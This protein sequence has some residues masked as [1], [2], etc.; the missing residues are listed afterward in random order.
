MNREQLEHAL[1]AAS[2]IT[3]ER[4]MF[5]IGSQSI[6]GSFS[7]HM[8]PARAVQSEEV[9]V[10]FFDDPDG[11]KA[12]LVEGA[13]GEY[14]TFYDMFKFYVDGV[15]LT[16]AIL[17]EGWVDRLVD[18]TSART[19]GAVGRCLEPHDCVV[20]KMAAGREKDWEFVD[21]LLGAGLV[22]SDVL[23]ER[24]D[25]TEMHPLARQRATDWLVRFYPPSWLR[26]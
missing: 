18:V 6:L 17:P 9:D 4:V 1:R 3:G 7:E 15:D 13:I 20:S 5:V 26:R 10:G 11:I 23:L 21:A 22:Q 25:L 2:E 24:M 14:S 12:D 8:L 16:T 19:N